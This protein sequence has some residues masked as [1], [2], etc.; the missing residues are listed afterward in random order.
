MKM[1]VHA[2][3]F[4]L[5]EPQRHEVEREVE[6]LAQGCDRPINII[7]IDLF[8]HRSLTGPGQQRCRVQVEFDDNCSV[9]DS[10]TEERFHDSI[11]EAFAKVLRHSR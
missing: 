4:V 5:S 1:E 3:G 10:D 8:E 11:T 7:S 6:R 9:A 2:H